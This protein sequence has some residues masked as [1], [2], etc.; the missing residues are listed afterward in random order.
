MDCKAKEA[1]VTLRTVRCSC[2][3]SWTKDIS[4]ARSA[5]VRGRFLHTPWCLAE[6]P[7][8]DAGWESMII[9]PQM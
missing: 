8:S 9:R 1:V 6:V 3:L 2:I 5:A 7:A 4:S